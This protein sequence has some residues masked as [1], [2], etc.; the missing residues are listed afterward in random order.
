MGRLKKLI[1]KSIQFLYRNTASKHD[2]GFEIGDTLDPLF[3][4]MSGTPVDRFLLEK[5]FLNERYFDSLN[6]SGTQGIE[7]GDIEYL[8]LYFNNVQKSK[9]VF[10]KDQPLKTRSE[11]E[12]EGDLTVLNCEVSDHFDVA[13]FTQVLVFVKDDLQA[14]KNIKQMMKPNG[15]LIGSESLVAP[16]SIYDDSRWGENR[17]YSPRSLRA[18]LELEFEIID[19]KV[20][21]N[22]V[23]SAA[24]VLGVPVESLDE[25]LLNKSRQSHGTSMFYIAKKFD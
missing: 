21:G 4:Y 19:F 1:I 9:L 13:I 11:H 16:I 17:R 3:G 12:V 5:T 2:L 7:V 8:S 24:L 25:N 6:K 15:V 23:S 14:I 22:A 20:L 18:L 10:Q